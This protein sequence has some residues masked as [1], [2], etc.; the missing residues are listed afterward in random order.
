VT[1]PPRVLRLPARSLVFDVRVGGP[2]D[3]EPTLL[4]HGFPQH[5]GMWS[6]VEP[7]LHAARLRTIAPDQR[8][9]SPGARPELVEAYRVS[10]CVAD[11][12]SILDGLGV[13]RAHVVGHDWGALVAWH[14]AGLHADRLRTLTA[15]SVPH[16]RALSAALVTD[17]DQRERSSYVR[18][19]RRVGR[20]ED[21]LLADGAARLRALFAGVDAGRAESYVA[22]ML[23]PGALTAALNWYRAISV[24]DAVGPGPVSVP[25]TFI[26]S[27]G[28]IA[29]GATAAEGC[30]AHVSGDFRFVRL[31]GV[32][33]WVPDESPHAVAGAVLARI[34]PTP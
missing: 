33:H 34:L 4:L 2:D 8:G 21:V 24:R 32:S 20:A 23:A 6:Q 10:E 19:F 31:P 15:I 16:P 29:I 14:L 12:L 1:S 5:A 25:T 17:A 13:D 28:D 3:G 7:S 22:P 9:Y 30:A 26:W 11:A 27:D 18:L